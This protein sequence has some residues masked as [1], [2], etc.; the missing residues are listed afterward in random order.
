VK[1]L[2]KCLEFIKSNDLKSNYTILKECQNAKVLIEK[3][4]RANTEYKGLIK[5]GQ[6][7]H[8]TQFKSTSEKVKQLRVK[9]EAEIVKMAQ[10]IETR[11]ESIGSMQSF[12]DR[13][14]KYSCRY[15]LL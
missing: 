9:C 12:R 13:F 10:E 15:R 14:V 4:A 11:R 3:L 5:G 8:V 1:Q 7:N 6:E 2:E